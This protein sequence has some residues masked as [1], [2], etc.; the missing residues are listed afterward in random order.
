[1]ET[2][3]MTAISTVGF[4]IVAC[5]YMAYLNKNQTEAHKEE[6]SKVTEALNALK[7]IITELKEKI[8]K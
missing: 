6:I 2:E 5:F 7:L 4:P 8:A 1:M 3:I